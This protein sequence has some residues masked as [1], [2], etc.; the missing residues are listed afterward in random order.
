LRAYFCYFPPQNDMRSVPE[1]KVHTTKRSN[2][3]GSQPFVRSRFFNADIAC[4]RSGHTSLRS[5]APFTSID[6]N[7]LR[8]CGPAGLIIGS[9]I[10]I[11]E[12]GIIGFR[13]CRRSL[14]KFVRTERINDLVIDSKAHIAFAPNECPIPTKFRLRK[15]ICA[16]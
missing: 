10:M 14:S 15:S 13:C 1:Q 16:P 8:C 4:S 6:R 5:Y 11:D 12:N 2:T 7:F 3:R 9:T